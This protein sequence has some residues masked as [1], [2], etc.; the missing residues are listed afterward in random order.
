MDTYGGDFENLKA[1]FVK[2]VH[3]LPF[4]GGGVW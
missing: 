2:F 1:A 4:C 3:N